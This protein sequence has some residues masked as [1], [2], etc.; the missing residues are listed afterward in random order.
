M[1]TPPAKSRP[2]ALLQLSH[3]LSTSDVSAGRSLQ[4][5]LIS[6]YVTET[7]QDN[8]DLFRTLIRNHC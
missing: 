3:E 7:I 5:C 8:T 2:F 1:K 6:D 4:F